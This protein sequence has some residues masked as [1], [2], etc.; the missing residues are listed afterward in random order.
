MKTLLSIFVAAVLLCGCAGTYFTFDKAKQVQVGMTE[1]QV[2]TILG[3]PYMITSGKD[4]CRW[5]YSY[6]DGFGTARS[7][8]FVLVDGKVSE[9][10][11]IPDRFLKK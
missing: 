2:E 11:A 10:P 1:A 6:A 5:I 4:G 7:I 9:V 3:S 8:S